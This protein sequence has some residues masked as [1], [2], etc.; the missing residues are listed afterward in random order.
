M[1]EYRIGEVTHALD[2][3]QYTLKHYER[4]G[5]I[6][7]HASPDSGFRFYTR[8]DFGRII[9]IRS[10]R[11]MGFSVEEISELLAGDVSS[12]LSAFESKREENDERIRELQEANRALERRA[13]SLRAFV[14]RPAEGE[15]IDV[16]RFQFMGHFRNDQLSE[17]ASTLASSEFWRRSY[18]SAHL[19]LRFEKDDL[20]TDSGAFWWGLVL[21]EDELEEF[22]SIDPARAHESDEKGSQ[23]GRSGD[24]AGG[25]GFACIERVE[26]HRA[27]ALSVSLG[28]E[29]VFAP[30]HSLVMEALAKRGATLAGDVYAVSDAQFLRNPVSGDADTGSEMALTV[31]VPLLETGE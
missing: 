3:G 21:Y 15:I 10:L 24:S 11:R 29:D 5:L 23:P 1:P 16:P 19:A 13:A 25:D 18:E 20:E 17:E 28:S 26:A 9:I 22:H 4:S 27:L 30:L 31:E 7:P 14:D 8:H 2:L 12:T 6:T